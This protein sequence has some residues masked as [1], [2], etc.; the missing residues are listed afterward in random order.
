LRIHTCLSQRAK[1]PRT[2]I[3]IFLISL[4]LFSR[5]KLTVTDSQPREGNSV[6][7]TCETQRPLER[8]DTR[9][10]FIFFRG[11]GVTLSNWSRSPELHITAIWRED[12]GTY[13]CGAET[14]TSGVHKLSLPLQIDVQSE[15]WSQ[16]GRA[17]LWP[18]ADCSF[19]PCG[20]WGCPIQIDF[21]ILDR[22]TR[23]RLRSEILS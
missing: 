14:V 9:L 20:G 13:W 15:C 16:V 3:L 23:L 2:E 19:R 21:V 18:L 7:L 1:Y 11:S 22:G 17:R 4:E 6:N 12:S 5:P 10:H 8:P